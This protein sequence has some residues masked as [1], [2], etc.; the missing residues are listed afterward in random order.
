VLIASPNSDSVRV[1][2]RKNYQFF[3][4]IEKVVEIG[5]NDVWKLKEESLSNP[6]TGD[7]L[8]RISSAFVS[9]WFAWSRFYPNTLVYEGPADVD[10]QPVSVY[11]SARLLTTWGII[12]QANEQM[13]KYAHEQMSKW[14]NAPIISV[15]LSD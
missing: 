15:N 8:S 14:T 13:S 6:K 7:S 12:K 11:P 9:F 1:Y 5:T 2:E 3:G 10:Q 4:S